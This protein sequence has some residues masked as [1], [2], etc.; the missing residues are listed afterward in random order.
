[1]R[2]SLFFAKTKISVLVV[3]V[4]DSSLVPV[5]DRSLVPH[6]GRLPPCGGGGQGQGDPPRPQSHASWC[7]DPLYPAVQQKKL[8]N[9]SKT[10]YLR[11]FL[12]KK[13]WFYNVDCVFLSR[14]IAWLIDL[15]LISSLPTVIFTSKT[16]YKTGWTT[17]ES[18]RGEI[19]ESIHYVQEVLAHF[20]W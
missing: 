20:I 16:S 2:K 3:P 12:L 8:S 14:K 11:T 1:M 17:L 13:N 5:G 4:R 15:N 10:K 19:R 9:C 6:Q 18:G 7:I